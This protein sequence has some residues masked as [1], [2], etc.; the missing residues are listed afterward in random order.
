VNHE[1]LTALL[2]YHYWARDRMLD[3]LADLAPEDYTKGLGSSFGSIRDT[4]VHI[5][6]AEWLWHARWRG[7][8]PSEPVPASHFP[9]VPSLAHAWLELEAR[10]R[11]MV[12]EMRDEDLARVIEYRTL[13]GEAVSSVFWHMVQ[14]VVNHATYH[15]GQVT[16]LLR[17]LNVRPPESTDL[18][19]F[20]RR[21]PL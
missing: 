5:Y 15:R 8:S 2:D 18:I 11:S 20:Y 3:A 14:H 13:D 16:T 7:I 17:Q 9:D 10:V 4:V 1:A 6:L 21:P 12:A 19:T